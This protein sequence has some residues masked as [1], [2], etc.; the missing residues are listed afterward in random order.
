MQSLAYLYIRWLAS[1][2]EDRMRICVSCLYETYMIEH[3]C[4][5]KVIGD[6]WPES[7]SLTVA[8]LCTNHVV[9]NK[10][11]SKRRKGE[12]SGG[13]GL[14]HFSMKVCEKVE[15]KGITTYNE[16]A[17]ELVSELSDL[18]SGLSDFVSVLSCLIIA[19]LL[20]Q[21]HVVFVVRWE[22]VWCEISRVPCTKVLSQEIQIFQETSFCVLQVLLRNF[23][24]TLWQ[25]YMDFYTIR[26]VFESSFQ[27]CT[28][29]VAILKKLWQFWQKCVDRTFVHVKHGAMWAPY[30]W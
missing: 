14:R 10:I 18:Q 19:N 24:N 17:D 13:K 29:K 6:Y 7:V 15:K 20:V 12:K 5:L 11:F 2:S 3:C 30:Y 21:Y 8:L 26:M 1:R 22:I 16:V 9:Y 4:I 28:F 23:T 27:L 25:M